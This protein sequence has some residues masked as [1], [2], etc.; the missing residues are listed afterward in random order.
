MPF[1]NLIKELLQNH[2]VSLHIQIFTHT[3][4]SKTTPPTVLVF[5]SLGKSIGQFLSLRAAGSTSVFASLWFQRHSWCWTSR[6][7][8]PWSP[9]FLWTDPCNSPLARLVAASG[10]PSHS[11]ALWPG[12]CSGSSTAPRLRAAPPC[13]SWAAPAARQLPRTR[14]CPESR[15]GSCLEPGPQTLGLALTP[16]SCC[17][18]SQAPYTRVRLQWNRYLQEKG[19]I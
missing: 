1:K 3:S 19:I 5:P 16:S 13:S 17:S 14:M 9:A 8:Y 4:N 7:R 12:G 6:P 2:S 10:P 11:T 18:C 15:P